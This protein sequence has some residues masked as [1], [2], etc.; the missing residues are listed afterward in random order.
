MNM[1]PVRLKSVEAIRELRSALR[2]SGTPLS[3]EEV[4]SLRRLIRRVETVLHVLESGADSFLRLH[5]NLAKIRKRAGAV[6]DMDV[7]IELVS[8]LPIDQEEECLFKVL[9]YLTSK[10]KQ[11]ALK[12]HK[13]I[14]R[15]GSS[16]RRDLKNLSDH[17]EKDSWMRKRDMASSKSSRARPFEVI[18]TASEQLAV[19]PKLRRSNLHGFRL[20]ARELRSALQLLG[21]DSNGLVKSLGEVKDAIGEWHDWTVLASTVGDAGCAARSEVMKEIERTVKGK[22]DFAR[23]GSNA[24]RRRLIG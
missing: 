19:W 21:H 1:G 18:S 17:I 5:G 23:F 14:V 22:Y 6:R 10:R 12:L 3:P 11:R 9:E 4:H 16:T 24:I 13:A 15:H 7:L 8:A 2:R 20:R